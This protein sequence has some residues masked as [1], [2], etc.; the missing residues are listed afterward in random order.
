M[1]KKQKEEVEKIDGNFRFTINEISRFI[2]AELN[3]ELF[4][5]IYGEGVVTFRRRIPEKD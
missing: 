3:Q 1:L 4:D 5:R 2:P